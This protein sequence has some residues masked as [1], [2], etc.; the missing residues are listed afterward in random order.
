MEKVLPGCLPGP[1]SAPR[2]TPVRCRRLAARRL[3]PAA[4]RR[5]G[6]NPDKLNRPPRATAGQNSL[7]IA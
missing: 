7:I 2:L 3:I 1:G 5:S 6:K 4:R